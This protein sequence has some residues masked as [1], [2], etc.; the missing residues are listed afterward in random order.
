MQNLQKLNIKITPKIR[1]Y[2][3]DK[4]GK[5]KEKWKGNQ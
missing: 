3:F 4:N 5:E 2:L 1:L